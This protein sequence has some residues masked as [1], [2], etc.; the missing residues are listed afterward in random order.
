MSSTPGVTSKKRK[1]E[2]VPDYIT[3]A[4]SRPEPKAKKHK[5]E[6]EM[7]G[8]TIMARVI[9]ENTVASE[10][11]FISAEKAIKLFDLIHAINKEVPILDH[12]E[13]SLNSKE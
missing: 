5:Y 11:F 1:Y 8:K 2:E 12:P 3:I 10:P 7:S 13:I 9:F 6:E 4:N